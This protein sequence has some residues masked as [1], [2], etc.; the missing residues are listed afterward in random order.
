MVEID[1]LRCPD[2]TPVVFRDNR[3][4]AGDDNPGITDGTGVVWETPRQEVL[5]A[6]VL[7]TRETVPSLEEA[8]AVLSP[9]V[10]GGN[11]ELKNSGPFDVRPGEALERG[12]SSPSS[13]SVGSVRRPSNRELDGAVG[14]RLVTSFHEPAVAAVRAIVPDVSAGIPV[15]AWIENT[16]T[17]AERYSCEA[18][19]PHLK[20]GAR[21]SAGS[22]LPARIRLGRKSIFYPRPTTSAVRSTSGSFGLGTNLTACRRPASTGSSRIARIF[23]DGPDLPERP[24]LKVSLRTDTT[25]T[26]EASMGETFE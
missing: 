17:V 12:R 8:L 25:A 13:G 11:V 24:E 22:H 21:R 26:S 23:S 1:V 15:G 20:I 14:E 19:H 2:G 9:K 4:D 7:D 10:G 18:I 3:L 6:R 5:A 16:L